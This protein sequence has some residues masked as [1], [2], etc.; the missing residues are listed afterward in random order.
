[1]EGPCHREDAKSAKERGVEAFGTPTRLSRELERRSDEGGHPADGQWVIVQL[2][3][4]LRALG[5]FAVNLP[6]DLNRMQRPSVDFR[7]RLGTESE[8]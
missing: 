3:R 4:I 5:V 7:D 1:M 8:N 2:S 6:T